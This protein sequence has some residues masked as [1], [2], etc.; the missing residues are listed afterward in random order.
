MGTA[1]MA[2]GLESGSCG[3]FWNVARPE[4]ILEIQRRYAQAG[5]DGYGA[6]ASSAVDLFIR[7]TAEKKQAAVA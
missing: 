5:A 7:L 1:L 6:D 4:T 2:A 3:E